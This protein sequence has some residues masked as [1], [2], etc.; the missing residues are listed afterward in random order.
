MGYLRDQEGIMNRYLRESDQWE[1]HLDRTR[2]FIKSSFPINPEGKKNPGAVAVLG[3]GWLLDVPLEHLTEAFESVDLVDINHP[4]QIKKKT[5]KLKN[6][7]L[8]EEDLSGGAI[9]QVWNLTRGKGPATLDDFMASLEF[10]PPLEG[11]ATSALISLNLL[12]QLDIILCDYLSRKLNADPEI[13]DLL[14]SRIQ[15][16][17]LQW[18]T[19]KP[20]CLVTDIREI[21]IHRD[22]HREEKSLLFARLPQGSHREQWKWEFDSTGSYRHGFRSIMEVEAVSWYQKPLSF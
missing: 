1:G 15:K 6:V 4:P 5:E 10:T 8:V 9:E 21:S 19:R 7:V 18:I 17:H 14:R 20:G 22:G 2:N 12:N 11:R 3:S 13:L 16:D